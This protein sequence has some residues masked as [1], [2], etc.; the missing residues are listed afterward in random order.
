M[1]FVAKAALLLLDRIPR[2]AVFAR[3]AAARD[4]RHHERQA[5]IAG[6]AANGLDEGPHA[7]AVV[8]GTFSGRVGLALGPDHA[9]D[10]AA[11]VAEAADHG[12]EQARAAQFALSRVPLLHRSAAVGAGDQTLR[13][14]GAALHVESEGEAWSLLPEGFARRRAAVNQGVHRVD[15]DFHVVQRLARDVPLVVHVLGPDMRVWFEAAVLAEKAG[16]LHLRLAAEE[17]HVAD[18]HVPDR[19]GR[20]HLAL[21]ADPQRDLVGPAG[22]Q[23]LQP[24]GETTVRG[25]TD[26]D[27]FEP[28][29][30]GAVAQNA[31]LHCAG[32][33]RGTLEPRVC[34]SITVAL[35]HDSVTQ[36]ASE[37][38]R[39]SISRRIF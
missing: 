21:V 12:P 30:D 17:P 32:R 22:P 18:Q 28:L 15:S 3:I 23:A 2:R 7:R 35:Q 11:G 27:P 36:A 4:L 38:H 14:A 9:L 19:A 31:R 16:A 8:G 20:G 33:S 39:G 10:A 26:L 13:H 24:A 1:Y 25:A 34:E 6:V 5:R 37:V 29:D